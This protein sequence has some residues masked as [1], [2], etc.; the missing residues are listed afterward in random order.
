M[1]HEGHVAA[2]VRVIQNR[3]QAQAAAE[4]NTNNKAVT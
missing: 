3:L 1:F 4:N 2:A